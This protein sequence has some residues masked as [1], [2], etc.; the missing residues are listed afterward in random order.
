MAVFHYSRKA[1]RDLAQIWQYYLETGGIDVA[2]DM[3]LKIRNTIQRTLG[4]FPRS[5]RLRTEF[6]PG[7]RSYPVPPYVVFY[8]TGER[9]MYVLRLLHGHR[10]IR[11]PLM[12]LLTA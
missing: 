4:R 6:G 9:G 2:H 1:S 12:S 7:V 10:D 11:A 5:G 8:V 3:I